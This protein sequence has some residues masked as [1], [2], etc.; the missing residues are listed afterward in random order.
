[1]AKSNIVQLPELS[2]L[3]KQFLILEKQQEQ[4][5]EQAKLIAEKSNG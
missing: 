1:L 4:I 2:E 5:R 3:D